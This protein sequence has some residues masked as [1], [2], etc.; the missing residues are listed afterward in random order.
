MELL[1][2]ILTTLS[3]SLLGSLHCVGMCGAFVIVAS[4]PGESGSS[5]SALLGWYNVGRL[6]TYI[7][8]GTLAGLLGAGVNTGG[9]L[10][11]LGRLAAVFAGGVMVLFGLVTLARIAGARVPRAPL[12]A[13]LLNFS[14]RAHQVV[15]GWRPSVRACAIGLLTTLLPCGW[16]YAFVATAAGTGSP[17]LGAAT[18]AAFWLGTLPAMVSVGAGAQRLLGPLAR[19][20]P[21]IASVAVVSVGAMTIVGRLNASGACHTPDANGKVVCHEP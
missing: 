5:K 6:V 4:T 10:I 21:V 13:F 16:L 8:L 11:G 14:R 7:V 19:H 9:E 12:P 15:F 2:L 1:P 20:T 3:A 17:L 18:M